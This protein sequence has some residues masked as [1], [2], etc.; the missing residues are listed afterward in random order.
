MSVTH[1]PLLKQDAV[2]LPFVFLTEPELDA[3]F[4]VY[5]AKAL[6]SI[7]PRDFLIWKEI[8]FCFN[9]GQDPNRQMALQGIIDTCIWLKTA[10]APKKLSPRADV[11]SKR[12]KLSSKIEIESA[13]N[14]SYLAHQEKLQL[15]LKTSSE[16]EYRRQLE[17]LKRTGEPFIESKKPVVKY[18]A[19]SKLIN[20]RRKRLSLW[21]NRMQYELHALD[22]L[23]EQSV[24]VCTKN[25]LK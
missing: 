4:S 15:E 5:R 12:R 16:L 6:V 17:I 7:E 14:E 11:E 22:Q 21:R 2:K 23:T 10:R 24:G 8:Q 18:M 20:R 19:M 13:R 3:L 25:K 9:K 1:S